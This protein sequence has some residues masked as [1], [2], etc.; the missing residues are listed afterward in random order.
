MRQIEPG[1]SALVIF[2]TSS[3]S[4]VIDDWRQVYDPYQKMIPP[5]ITIAYPFIPEEQWSLKCKIIV[6]GLRTVKPFPVM[7]KE[8]GYFDKKAY[9]LWLKPE[10]G[11]NLIHIHNI[12]QHLFPE[13]FSSS[14]LGY[15][16][17]LTLGFFKSMEE[18]LKAKTTIS[19]KWKPIEFIASKI[20]Y[21]VFGE[22]TVW[23][24]KDKLS[25]SSA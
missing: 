24:I 15:I 17:H 16:P 1:E 3:I 8:L 19:A 25:L 13:Y 7:L 6:A 5:H 23:H 22:N 21:A 9:V 20:H 14:S 10:C 18:L 2:P 12:L 4:S 11:S